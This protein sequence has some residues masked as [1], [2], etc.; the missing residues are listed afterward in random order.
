MEIKQLL[1][2][3]PQKGK[4]EWIGIRSK[5]RAELEKV[6][7]VAVSVADGLEGDHYKGRSKK[8]QVTFIQAEYLDVVAAILKKATIDPQLTRR[9]IVV[10]GINLN[11]LKGRQ[12]RIGS[13]VILEVTGE[14]HPCSR[15]E[16]NLGAGGY[17]AMR[18]HGGITSKVIQ[19]GIIRL[20]D[21]LELLITSVEEEEQKR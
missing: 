15:M 17:N 18:S 1:N 11:A 8:R 7:Q 9:N 13:E 19:G 5:R 16:E 12:F 10:S 3:M 21:T 4:V 2:I 6:E 20:G 14:C